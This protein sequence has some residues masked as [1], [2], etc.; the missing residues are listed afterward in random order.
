MRRLLFSLMI[1]SFFSVKSQTLPIYMPT[2]GLLAW[3][4][5]SSNAA[6]SSGSGYNGTVHAATLTYD[7]FGNAGKAYHFDGVS[8]Y[9]QTLL[10]P[11]LG[12]A[13]RTITLWLKYDDAAGFC[14][15]AMAIAGYGA[16]TSSCSQN[17][18]NFSLEVDNY[19]GSPKARV[20]GVCIATDVAGDSLDNQWHFFAAVYDPSYGDFFGIRL[21]IDG[22]YEPT[23]TSVFGS[24]TAV[25]TDTFSKFDIGKGHYECERFFKGA[26]DDITVW[27]RA[28]T[29]GEL[30]RLFRGMP[31]AVSDSI[32]AYVDNNCTME[33]FTIVPRSPSSA[34]TARIWYGDGSFQ[35]ATI[36][37]ST[38][39]ASFS[40]AYTSSG[41]YTIKQVIYNGTTPL[42]S[43]TF[44]H[45]Y[46]FCRTFSISC[47]YDANGN[48]QRDMLEPSIYQPSLMEIDSA[49][50]VIDTLPLT[51]TLNYNTIGP[52]GT[53]Y[54]F[55]ILS[56][57]LGLT[58]SCPSTGIIFDTVTT[59]ADHNKKMAFICSSASEH[60]LSVFT[61][62]R[63]G[64]HHFGGTILATNSGGIPPF[65]QLTM[66]LNPKYTSWLVFTP[67][68]TAIVGNVATWDI[69][70]LSSV[71]PS[72]YL[73]HADMEGGAD[74]GDTVLTRYSITPTV[75]DINL[76]NN[77]DDRVDT[78]KAGYDPNDI[79]VKPNGCLDPGIHELT[80]TVHFENTGN[81]TAFN[82]FVLD[83]LLPE[84]DPST[85]R[86]KAASA[87]MT[88]S[89]A[90]WGATT[91]ARF[92]FPHINLL[93]SSHHGQNEGM[94]VYSIKSRNLNAGSY[95]TNRAGIYFDTNPVVL[96]NTAVNTV[97]CETAVQ[98]QNNDDE[99]YI[100][101]NPSKG[102][103]QV[104]VKGGGYSLIDITDNIG[105]NVRSKSL[106]GNST[107]VDISDLPAGIY[108]VMLR[109]NAGLRMTR[110]TKL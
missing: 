108:Y 19:Y 48:C 30:Y 16:N 43:V 84:L 93:D 45:N 100:Y 35:T 56:T 3:Y 88:T 40:H 68:P 62:F 83:T 17:C 75:G 102:I 73:I 80:Y 8:S 65:A 76:I 79:Q 89:F 69:A 106:I 42:D 92:D 28:L 1:L 36:D 37:D 4:P 25:A 94:F 96:T 22:V 66:H 12:N 34:T 109:G 6:D 59:S 101:P 53:V 7:R 55:R 23:V 78:V 11:P 91:I 2:G 64:V 20:D 50:V 61:S 63:A 54:R 58:V 97:G 72:P 47:Y 14:E 71:I 18:A 52:T 13:P 104:K 74:I 105:R 21:Y 87:E 95:V 24:I 90:S 26:I 15:P 77:N 33:K 5:F 67:A 39:Y 44:V 10:T 46:Q 57:V 32:F 86:I 103:I 49:G 29:P 51:S 9:I 110:L 99:V 85:L 38:G 31:A 107:L 70:T 41:S 82:I 98:I 60:D 27:N 81:D